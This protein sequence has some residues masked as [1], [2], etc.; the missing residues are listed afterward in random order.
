ML[1]L[2]DLSL[3]LGEQV[4]FK[5]LSFHI[6]K[7]ELIC[8]RGK[9]GSGKTTL[10]DLITGV[11]KPDQGIICFNGENVTHESELKRGRWVS[12]LA[13]NTLHGCFSSLTVKENFVLA[14]AKGTRIGL[15]QCHDAFP[16]EKIYH[17]LEGSKI[18]IQ[19]MLE[20][21]MNALSGG[22]RQLL[23][24]LMM[25]LH[26]PQILLLDEPTAAL[27]PASSALWTDLAIRYIHSHRVTTILIT[28]D[29][30]LMNAMNGRIWAVINKC[31]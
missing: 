30:S 25:L 12:R 17:L 21:P 20:R 19:A 24:F 27:D 9:N 15:K 10:F 13:Q 4:I 14:A 18:D 7:G 29:D 26:D 22:Q 8:L 6:E 28:H 1:I 3:R 2:K 11:K 31:F 23:N 5:G 16:A